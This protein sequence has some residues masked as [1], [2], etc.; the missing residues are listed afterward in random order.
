[1]SEFFDKKT[2]EFVTLIQRLDDVQVLIKFENGKFEVRN[3]SDLKQVIDLAIDKILSPK[4]EDDEIVL[5]EEDEVKTVRDAPLVDESNRPVKLQKINNHGQAVITHENSAVSTT[6]GL[7]QVFFDF[8]NPKAMSSDVILL[9]LSKLSDVDQKLISKLS[10]IN[11]NWNDIMNSDKIWANLLMKKYPNHYL[12]YLDKDGMSLHPVMKKILDQLTVDDIKNEETGFV[13]QK[14]GQRYLKRFFEWITKN[15]NKEQSIHETFHTGEASTQ[16]SISGAKGKTK[17]ITH[18]WQCGENIFVLF[19]D[20]YEDVKTKSGVHLAQFNY[21]DDVF[22]LLKQEPKITNLLNKVVDKVTFVQHDQHGF[23]VKWFSNNTHAYFDINM[24]EETFT[25]TKYEFT[26]PTNILLCPR[27]LAIV[28]PGKWGTEFIERT[29]KMDNKRIEPNLFAFEISGVSSFNCIDRT[30]QRSYVTHE[31]KHDYYDGPISYVDVPYE[32][33]QVVSVSINNDSR[34]IKNKFKDVEASKYQPARTYSSTMVDVVYSEENALVTSDQLNGMFEYYV[35]NVKI[36]GLEEKQTKAWVTFATGAH[37]GG[38]VYR[39][40][41]GPGNYFKF[42][43]F[44]KNNK[45][46]TLAPHLYY[47]AKEGGIWVRFVQRMSPKDKLVSKCIECNFADAKIANPKNADHLFCD[48][49]CAAT[50]YQNFSET[51]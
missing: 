19:S 26:E 29:D 8:S 4:K 41:P 45:K 37:Y 50:F 42:L 39:F 35:N 27:A 7:N 28:H 1:M 46:G 44:H 38:S 49:S 10:K 23:I 11:K 6:V 47:P 36:A 15:N 12:H 16:Y 20:K 33:F 31:R 25:M 14:K 24:D 21:K 30:L 40:A 22:E 34:A 18:I 43:I 5:F 48:K 32:R 17:Y 2:K 3:M 9:I 13:R 51:K